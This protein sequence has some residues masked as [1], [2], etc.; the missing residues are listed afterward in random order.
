[1]ASKDEP[2]SLILS[3][4]EPFKF[5]ISIK[6]KNWVRHRLGK[7]FKWKSEITIGDSYIDNE[8]FVRTDN[9]YLGVEFLK[10][11][12]NRDMVKYFFDNGF[13]EIIGTKHS[14]D[15]IKYM[16][17]DKDLRVDAVLGY[18]EKL[19]HFE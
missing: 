1:M 13:H 2:S 9:P 14:F 10:S 19:G 8:C 11:T 3:K 16:Y 12:K 18:L 6:S 15:A 4:K 17:S 7:S 5:F